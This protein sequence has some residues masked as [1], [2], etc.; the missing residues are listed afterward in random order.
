VGGLVHLQAQT[1]SQT[2]INKRD[3]YLTTQTKPMHNANRP[4]GYL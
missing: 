1:N 3:Y 4:C 2:Q